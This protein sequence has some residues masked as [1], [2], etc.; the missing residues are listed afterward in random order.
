MGSFLSCYHEWKAIEHTY[1]WWCCESAKALGWMCPWH[2]A[3]LHP[4]LYGSLGSQRWL[5]APWDSAIHAELSV[6]TWARSRMDRAIL[7]W[8]S[9]YKYYLRFSKLPDV[10]FGHT[11]S[12]MNTVKMRTE[13]S[14]DSKPYFSPTH[15]CTFTL[16]NN[17]L[18]IRKR[19]LRYFEQKSKV[20][21]QCVQMASPCLNKDIYSPG[22]QCIFGG[23]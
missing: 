23:A 22:I 21:L 3:D 7:R 16:L 2:T 10:A 19:K 17:N 18:L 14:L 4:M 5:P 9:I 15:S 12:R 6:M 11:G 1:G 20:H 13:Y 8:R